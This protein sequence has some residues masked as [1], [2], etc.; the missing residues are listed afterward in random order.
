MN[1]GTR[2]KQSEALLLP[3]KKMNW[4]RRAPGLSAVVICL[5]GSGLVVAQQERA[6]VLKGQA[7]FGDWHSDKPGVRRLLTPR[8]MPPPGNNAQTRKIAKVVPMPAG[9]RPQ[10]PAGFSVEL[11]AF[12]LHGPRAIRVAPNG[13]LFVAESESNTVRVL[14]IEPGSDKP[15]VNEV[16]AK[17]GMN[18][19]YGMAFYPSGPNPQWIYIANRDG[20][21]R[22]PYHNGDLKAKAKPAKIVEGILWPHHWTRDVVVSADGK[23]LFYSVGSGSNVALDMFPVP[24]DQPLDQWKKT[25]PL[26]AT[27]DTEEKRAN[28]LSFTP[29]GKDEQFV[30]TGLRNCTG[31]TLQPATGKLWCVVNERDELGDDTP[32]E[33]AT[34]VQAGAFYGWPWYYIGANED[35]R[36]KGKRPDLKNQVTIPAVLMQ[37]HSAPLQIAFYNADAFPSD[38]KGSAFVTMHG[39][40][41][42]S[43]RTGYKVVRLLFQNG[44]PTG[45]YEDFMTGFVISDEQ[46]W[47]RPVGVAVAKDGALL[48]GDDAGGTIWRV[49]HQ[50]ASPR[51]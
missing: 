40:W 49:T 44:K 11:V 5:L 30:A 33:Y 26:T 3:S 16:F 9:A 46:L 10:V 45:E 37:A 20:L 17:E 24:L 36:H 25:H 4:R 14:R 28:V 22:I 18:L 29:D 13:D 31:M 8:D 7:A 47:G 38:Y 51:R 50:P 42:R 32:F 34:D 48:V 39:S 6:A 23:R 12:G 21:V 1:T 27:W 19:P 43:R 41:N 35:P 15:A 2:G